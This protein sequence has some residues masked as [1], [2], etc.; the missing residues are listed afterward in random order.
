MSPD[1]SANYPQLAIRHFLLMHDGFEDILTST[2]LAFTALR[3]TG[4]EF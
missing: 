2:V 3:V 1:D 4:K